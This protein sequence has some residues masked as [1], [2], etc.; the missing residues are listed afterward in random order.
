VV[1]AVNKLQ[2]QDSKDA[3]AAQQ[4]QTAPNALGAIAVEHAVTGHSNS[5]SS[6]SKNNINHSNK[7]SYMCND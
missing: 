5:S 7:S 3:A 6:S 1:C 4:R 2:A